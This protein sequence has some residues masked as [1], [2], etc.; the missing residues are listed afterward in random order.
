MWLWI[1]QKPEHERPQVLPFS[2][3]KEIKMAS[4]PEMQTVRQITEELIWIHGFLKRVCYFREGF[5][6]IL[7][8]AK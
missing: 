8:L 3:W 7:F 2:L 5:F 1:L 4:Y 6:F